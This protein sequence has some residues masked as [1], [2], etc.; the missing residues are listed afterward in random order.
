[1]SSG[2]SAVIWRFPWS[3]SLMW[4]YP[5]MFSLSVSAIFFLDRLRINGAS[6]SRNTETPVTLKSLSAPSSPHYFNKAWVHYFNWSTQIRICSSWIGKIG[7][8]SQGPQVKGE[9]LV[10]VW[11]PVH[12]TLQRRGT[13]NELLPAD[14]LLH[15][16][17][18]QNRN[19][20][21]HPAQVR[22]QNT[23][24][25]ETERLKRDGNSE[26]KNRWWIHLLF[27]LWL[28]RPRPTSRGDKWKTR[29]F[30]WSE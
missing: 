14:A 4:F 2:C 30:D 12:Q 19:H 23:S 6:L 7:S 20:G 28:F 1:M 15:V 18:L 27:L 26:K 17:I 13:S 21:N 3:G 11:S 8:C 29:N 16:C 25:L 5:L 22:H 10:L 24:Q 9:A